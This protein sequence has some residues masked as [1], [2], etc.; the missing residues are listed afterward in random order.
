MKKLMK[1]FMTLAMFL[2]FAAV[3]PGETVQAAESPVIAITDV[4]SY[5]VM[6]PI[7]GRIFMED[8]SNFDPTAYRIS[9]YLQV[10]P[11]GQYWV[12]PTSATPY[13]E[14]GR[15]GS[16]S[17]VFITGGN[18]RIAKVL[19]VM[20]IPAA[21]TPAGGGFND[22]NN[23]AL[24]Y[25]KITRTEEGQVTVDPARE[26]PPF[27]N[28]Q[29]AINALLPVEED[30]IA[31]NIGF[32][33]DGSQPG[34]KLSETLIRRQ[35]TAVSYFS[36]IVRFYGSAGEL[37][38]AYKI[39]HDMGF[40]V[41]G[42][43]WLSGN[44]AADKTEMDA[45]IKHCNNGYVQVACVGNETLLRGD[46]TAQELID[47]I[48]YVR[49]NL[50]D[51]TIPLTTS[52]SVDILLGN[53][54][55][56]NAC[57]LIAPNVYPYWG[58]TA[59]SGAADAFI[60]SVENLAAASGGKQILVSETGWPTAGQSKGDAVPG[61]D[62]AAEYFDAV[63]AWSLTSGT[64]VLWF[65]AADEPWKV[66]DEGQS[67]RHWGL[68]TTDFE[69]KEG[70][71]G[72][73]FFTAHPYEGPGAIDISS[74]VLSGLSEKVYTGKAITQ[75]PVVKLGTVT[76]TAGTDYTVSYAENVK[77]GTAVVTVTGKGYYTGT[78]TG[79][80]RIL[81]KDVADESRWYFAPVYWALDNKV[82]SGY[83]GGTFQPTRQLT[84]AQAVAFLYNI[85]GQPDVNEYETKE[86]TDVAES[87]WYYNAVKWA[88][89]VGITSGMGPGMFQPDYVCNRAMI[90]TFLCSYAKLTGTYKEPGT[91]AGFT[92]V[93]A[94][95]WYKTSVDW[96]AENKVTSGYG[97]GTFG[98]MV[99]CNRAMM[100]SFL[101]KVDALPI[102]N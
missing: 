43:A 1:F 4:P 10:N 40:S 80:F 14:I 86:F 94:D 34:N 30:K 50:T 88:S 99:T 29:P 56:R 6:R 38:K 77:P 68:L 93:S 96:A 90:V 23:I 44:E 85:A 16:F 81:F 25:V 20:L 26:A 35:L 46:L 47:D 61:E 11:G 82:A 66:K 7:Q 63:R 28:V 84:R 58:G 3:F 9:I 27:S 45:L 78:V 87:A 54:S 73:E 65:E 69:L 62:A 12:K 37:D 49:E 64:Q 39:A 98:P 19:H 36:D 57:N 67:G 53:A 31:V 33:T 2:L 18:D 32:Y 89:A 71:A 13:V 41:V 24:D 60:E 5:N 95:A 97:Q 51:K 8:G 92:D 52:D 22:T 42:T 102:V 48:N 74:A 15:D 59:I 55:V 91:E 101:R 17:G 72:T 79:S 100:V 76:L 70:Y 75:A 21:Y 83:N